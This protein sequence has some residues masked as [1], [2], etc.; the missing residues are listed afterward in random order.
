[1]GGFSRVFLKF[2]TAWFV[3]TYDKQGVKICL[4]ACIRGTKRH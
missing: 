1:L 3:G 4:L 2:V